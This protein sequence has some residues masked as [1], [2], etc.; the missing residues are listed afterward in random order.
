[1]SRRTTGA[2]PA[3]AGALASLALALSLGACDGEPPPPPPPGDAGAEDAEVPDPFVDTDGDGLCDS[4]ELARGTDPLAI[5]T[6]D[7]GLTDRVE[8]DLGYQPTRPSSPERE[9]LVFLTENER[10]GVQVPIE[11]VVRGEG[12]NYTGTFEPLPVSDRLDLTAGD[13]FTTALAVGAV[14]RENVFEI[15][16]EEQR[17][18]GV[19]GRTQLVF[20][21]R[22]AFGDN[23]AR[24]CARAY[25]FRYQI[26]RSDG[27]LLY[28]GRFLLV[29][30]P[31]G[32]RLD[33]TEW[34]VFDGRCR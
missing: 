14:P 8:V 31:V 28:I 20:E 25:P 27:R 16:P 6:D 9:A 24:S 33:T 32:D 7:D 1:M 11:R 34:C 10:G 30:L 29:V 15:A 26:K 4:T 23:V 5:D 18:Y 12:E 3:R 22:F 21:V 17:F 13:F 2:R 19:V